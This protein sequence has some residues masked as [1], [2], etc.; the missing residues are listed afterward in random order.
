MRK[1]LLPTTIIMLGLMA[2]AYAQIV[3][4]TISGNEVVHVAQGPGGA[5]GLVS[6]NTIRNGESFAFTSGSGAAATTASGGVLMWIGTAPT[7]WTVTTPAVPF[8]GERITLSTDTTLTTMVTLSPAG[9]QI[10]HAP[11]AAQTLTALT[12]VSWRYNAISATWYRIQ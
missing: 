6:L 5:G 8:D 12:P 9:A 10:L 3:N 7:T 4:P 2:L 1:L 11:Y